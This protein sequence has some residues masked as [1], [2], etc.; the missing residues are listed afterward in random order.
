VDCLVIRGFAPQGHSRSL[1]F[2]HPAKPKM[3]DPGK[4][5]L[6]FVVKGFDARAGKNDGSHRCSVCL[7]RDTFRN[8]GR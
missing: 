4:G 7:P 2:L 5:L 3:F 1:E 8:D 6:A